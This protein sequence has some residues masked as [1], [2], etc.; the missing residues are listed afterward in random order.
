MKSRVILKKLKTPST[1]VFEKYRNVTNWE[2]TGHEWITVNSRQ[3]PVDERCD[4][5]TVR[6]VIQPF[7]NRIFEAAEDQNQGCIER[8]R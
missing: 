4:F 8:L 7:H 5:K 1:G 6:L 2:E 3:S